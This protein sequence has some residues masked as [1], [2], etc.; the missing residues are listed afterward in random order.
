[1]KGIKNVGRRTFLKAAAGTL[2]V[3]RM[4]HAAPDNR[5]KVALVGCG[6]RGNGAANHA[7]NTKTDVWLTAIAEVDEE[8]AIKG[9]EILKK[10]HLERVDVPDE[11]M[12]VGFEGYKQAIAE[13]DV[14]ILATPPGFRPQHFEEAVRQ[15][16]HVFMEKPVATDVAGILK[17]LKVAEEA[18]KKNLKVAV[19]MQRRHHPVYEEV[20]QRIHDGAIGDIH[21]M[22]A[23]WLGSSRGGKERLPGES[24]LAYQIRNWYYFTKSPPPPPVPTTSRNRT[25]SRTFASALSPLRS[26]QCFATISSISAF[27]CSN[28]CCTTS[29][30]SSSALIVQSSTFPSNA[31]AQLSRLASTRFA[32]ERTLCSLGR[33]RPYPPRIA[34]GTSILS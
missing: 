29:G 2:A 32:V 27:P 16:K 22:R 23:Y 25:I 8:Q 18:K 34:W 10:N 11:R 7:L 17:V 14:A 12:F 15:G 19:G 1:M 21:T 5:I 30:E 4:A 20:M 26:G 13:A 3:E 31:I 33:L 9:R 28:N 24:E 6:G